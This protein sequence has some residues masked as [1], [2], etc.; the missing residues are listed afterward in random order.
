MTIKQLA[1]LRVNVSK[2]RETHGFQITCCFDSEFELR[3][4]L[5]GGVS[6]YAVELASRL[7]N[8][9]GKT[10]LVFCASKATR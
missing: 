6:F 8:T 1:Q 4:W 5:K 9:A 3:V 7:F 2:N 10:L